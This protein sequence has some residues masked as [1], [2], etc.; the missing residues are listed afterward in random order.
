MGNSLG[1]HESSPKTQFL[2]TMGRWLRFIWAYSRVNRPTY[3]TQAK[4]KPRTH[5]TFWGI[6]FRTLEVPVLVH[7]VFQLGDRRIYMFEGHFGQVSILHLYN[8]NIYIYI[9]IRT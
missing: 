9:Y 3:G 7:E 2:T 1:I 6:A 4:D 5:L 8:H